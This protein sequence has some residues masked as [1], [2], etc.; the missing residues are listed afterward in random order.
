MGIRDNVPREMGIR[1]NVPSGKWGFGTMS[2][3]GNGN[4]VQCP[5]GKAG[6]RDNFPSG[7][8]RFGIMFRREKISSG[9]WV[10]GYS[11]NWDSGN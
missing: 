11:G 9:K 10:S 8:W 2:L 5:F 6:I 1:D 4:S 3:S 7:K